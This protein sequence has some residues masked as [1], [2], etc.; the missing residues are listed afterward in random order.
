M[1]TTPPTREGQPK[2][3]AALPPCEPWLVTTSCDG[4]R[5]GQGLNDSSWPTECGVI[6]RERATNAMQYPVT[7]QGILRDR[8]LTASKHNRL[9]FIRGLLFCKRGRVVDGSCLESIRSKGPWVQILP[10]AFMWTWPSWFMA[11]V[12]KTGGRKARRFKSY[13]SRLNPLAPPIGSK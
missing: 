4:E 1:W 8:C 2:P 10:L 5:N 13:R 11:P 7:S 9:R 3:M 6:L 12:S